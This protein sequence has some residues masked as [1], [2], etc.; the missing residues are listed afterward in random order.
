MGSLCNVTFPIIYFQ[1]TQHQVHL[2]IHGFFLCHWFSSHLESYILHNVLASDLFLRFDVKCYDRV[3]ASLI[4][5]DEILRDPC[6]IIDILCEEPLRLNFLVFLWCTLSHSSEN[7]SWLLWREEHILKIIKWLVSIVSCVF[8]LFVLFSW[9]PYTM[10]LFTKRTDT[11]PLD[12]VKSW[13][14]ESRV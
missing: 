2:V 5:D 14:H 4:C 7:G 12:L 3:G 10:P 11:L 1:I 13:T 8:W 6:I 9:W